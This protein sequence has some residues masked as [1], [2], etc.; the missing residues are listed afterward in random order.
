MKKIIG[1]VITI[2][3][4]L[5]SLVF[6][7]CV[8]NSDKKQESKTMTIGDVISEWEVQDLINIGYNFEQVKEIAI[9]RYNSTN[10][11]EEA[12]AIRINYFELFKNNKE[13]CDNGQ[14]EYCIPVGWLYLKSMG[15]K[16]DRVK[17]LEYFKKACNEDIAEACYIIG[18]RHDDDSE[19][20]RKINTQN[21]L[22]YINEQKRENCFIFDINIAKE[23]Y[24]KACDLQNQNGCNNYKKL[25]EQGY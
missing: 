10:N 13:K 15:V 14:L 24:G 4:I 6:I 20:P 16:Q 1:I 5:L 22:K 2:S 11:A 3:V 19:C 21:P 7:I 23:Y 12:K 17:A 9:S 25:N 8:I 18:I